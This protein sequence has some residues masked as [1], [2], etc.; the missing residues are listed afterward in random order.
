MA[1][2]GLQLLR[3]ARG[4][5]FG[6]GAAGSPAQLSHCWR[7]RQNISQKSEVLQTFHLHHDLVNIDVALQW[8]LVV[9]YAV[10]FRDG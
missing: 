7:E 8:F 6:I 5:R 4:F 9:N 2:V 1:K 3:K 10:I